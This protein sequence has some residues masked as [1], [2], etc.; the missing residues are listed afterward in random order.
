MSHPATRFILKV[1]W[2]KSVE[3]VSRP[4]GPPSHQG[5]CH[6]STITKEHVSPQPPKRAASAQLRSVRQAAGEQSCTPGVHARPFA[7]GLGSFC[8]IP[9]VPKL[10]KIPTKNHNGPSPETGIL[11]KSRPTV[12]RSPGE[13]RCPGP[14]AGHPKH[15]LAQPGVRAQPDWVR[16]TK[17]P[18]V[19]KLPKIPT[20]N[21]NGPPPA[22]G[23]LK[24]A[25]QL[26]PGVQVKRDALDRTLDTPSTILHNQ[27]FVRNRIRFVLQNPPDAQTSQNSHKASQ[28]PTTPTGNLKKPANGYLCGPLGL[29]PRRPGTTPSWSREFSAGRPS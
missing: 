6:F 9:P 4:S 20:K 24:K 29:V 21:H 12:T 5:P 23:I 14:S 28:R 19:P 26:S 7:A 27:A 16:F 8:K 2:P 3:T 15:N 17:S 10:P 22:T 25:G 1:A 11:K 18:P 13:T